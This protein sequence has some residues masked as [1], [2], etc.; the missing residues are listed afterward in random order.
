VLL[1]LPLAVVHL[2][3]ASASLQVVAA[4]WSMLVAAALHL[5]A[6][7]LLLLQWCI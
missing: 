3:A 1:L 5:M 2:M 7:L 4:E 6:L